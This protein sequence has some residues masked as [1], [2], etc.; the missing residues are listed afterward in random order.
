MSN[1]DFY[2]LEQLYAKHEGKTKEVKKLISEG[3]IQVFREENK[4]KLKPV[5]EVDQKREVK[6]LNSEEC[7]YYN[8]CCNKFTQENRTFIGTAEIIAGFLF[9]VYYILSRQLNLE[10]NRIYISSLAA[11]LSITE[12]SLLFSISLGILSNS[13]FYRFQV[14]SNQKTKEGHKTNL[15]QLF[16]KGYSRKQLSKILLYCSFAGVTLFWLVFI[17][18]I[19]ILIPFCVF[20]FMTGVGF[21]F[22][23]YMKKIENKGM[24]Q[25]PRKPLPVLEE[26]ASNI[27]PGIFSQENKININEKILLAGLQAIL[28]SE[29]VKVRRNAVKA[30]G[31][32]SENEAIYI[33][34]RYLGDTAPVV[35]AQVASVLGKLGDKSVKEPLKCLL[36]DEASEVRAAAADALGNLNDNTAVDILI[37]LLD[38]S[39]PEVRGSAAEA[40]GN[41]RKK[42]SIKPLLKQ[43]KDKDWFVRHK[44]IV[45]L[46]KMRDELPIDGIEKLMWATKE[47]NEYVSS[48]AKYV[49]KKIS[50]DMTQ[51]DP[52]YQEV[53]EILK[54]IDDDE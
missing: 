36:N 24:K 21:I 11:I 6:Y 50:G 47:S 12:I 32:I 51:K 38:D 9:I 8:A 14:L 43:I 26:S 27:F 49:L 45:A 10:F 17:S 40:L 3:A 15:L 13:Y 41:I 1:D 2:S 29:S 16:N 30:L 4:V 48:S 54:K 52:L 5:Q 22:Y 53:A 39:S 46:G 37:S 25:I 19:D 31:K 42:E 33:L 34:V 44:V 35:R 28:Q 7:N 20:F 23:N 18:S